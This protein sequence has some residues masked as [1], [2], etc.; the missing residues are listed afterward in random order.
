MFPKCGGI[1]IGADT[2]RNVP[3]LLVSD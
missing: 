2:A 3:Y 1:C